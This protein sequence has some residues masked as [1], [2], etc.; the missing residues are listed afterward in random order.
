MINNKNYKINYSTLEI[1]KIHDNGVK[2][3][4]YTN[5]NAIIVKIILKN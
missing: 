1:K 4:Q 2:K 3:C 5:I